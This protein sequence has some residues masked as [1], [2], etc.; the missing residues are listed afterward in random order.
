[1]LLAGFIFF[2]MIP[3]GAPDGE[4]NITAMNEIAQQVSRCWSNFSLLDKTD[5]AY[6]FVVID[7]DGAV[8]YSS[9]QNLPDNLTSA[10]RNGF[11]PMDI[12][13][14]LNTYGKVLIKIHSV[15][16]AE[17]A[18]KALAKMA[19]A[20]FVSLC[21]INLIFL[22]ALDSALVK[23][24]KRLE[25]FAHRISL[26]I[27]DEPLPMDK[28]NIFGLFTH[29]FDIMRL[30]LNEAREEQIKIERGKKELIASLS[31]D[32]KTPVTSIRLMAELLQAK[33][34]D[35]GLLEKLRAIEMKAD[36]IDRLMND[37]LHS[38]LEELGELKVKLCA[39]QSDRLR[40]VF[41]SAGYYAKITLGDI[42]PCIIEMDLMRMEQVVGNITANSQK[43][44]GTDIDVG[45]SI[46]GS[47]LQID[48]NDYGPGVGQ[49]ELELITAKFYRGGN[50]KQEK[51]EG[52][53]LYIGKLL[54]EKMGGRLEAINR[55]DGFTVRLYVKLL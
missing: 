6:P 22:W 13:A 37:I 46:S 8:V 25:R 7:N 4:I 5:F 15:D 9:H 18:E 54:M 47:L 51:G 42:P 36:Q 3:R 32:I 48:V 16:E 31:H 33:T 53:G 27:L 55:D 34:D 30:S 44:A 26:G 35:S 21:V 52:L 12:K 45:F 17:K 20:S 14:G 29:S 40:E 39:V 41:I 38:A 1:M 2:A 10:I 24:F 50:A 43:Y 49:E 23:P 19:L 28:H 11:V